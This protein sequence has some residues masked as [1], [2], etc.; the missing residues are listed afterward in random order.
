MIEILEL[1]ISRDVIKEKL[2]DDNPLKVTSNLKKTK[3]QTTTDDVIKRRP[4]LEKALKEKVGDPAKKVSKL[5]KAKVNSNDVIRK[6]KVTEN[7]KD[8]YREKSR[9]QKAIE[10]ELLMIP[11]KSSDSRTQKDTAKTETIPTH[12]VEKNEAQKLGLRV[13]DSHPNKV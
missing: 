9:T 10:S 5:E 1:K 3:A 6:R 4:D 2:Q 7:D 12:K 13:T 11:V 8:R